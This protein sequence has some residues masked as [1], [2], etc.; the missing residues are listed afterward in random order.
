MDVLAHVALWIA[1]F[2]LIVL[3]ERSARHGDGS[4]LFHAETPGPW[5]PPEWDIDPVCGNKVRTAN[6]KPS[7]HEGAAVY[8]CSRDCREIFEAAPDL[9]PRQKPDDAPI[10]EATHG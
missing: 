7:I 8:F 9:Y 3:L 2:A 10:Q 1:L 4:R 6:A 5:S